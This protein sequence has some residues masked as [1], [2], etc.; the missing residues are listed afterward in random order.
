MDICFTA[1]GLLSGPI[2]VT[3]TGPAPNDIAISNVSNSG[4]VVSLTLTLSSTT[5][6]GPR[7]L[8]VETVGRDKTAAS[9]A[10]EVK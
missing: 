6:P 3:I 4:L 2:V 9:G 8:F 10:I 5:L 1:S 7:T